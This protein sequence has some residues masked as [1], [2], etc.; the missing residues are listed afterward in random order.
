MGC[1]FRRSTKL[2]KKAT[3]AAPRCHSYRL[4]AISSGDAY[5]GR[6]QMSTSYEIYQTYLHG[7]TAVLRLFEQ[8]LGIQAIYGTPTPDMQQRTIECLSDEIGQLQSQ[9][10]RLQEELRDTRSDNHRLLRRNAELE[11]LV[12]KDSH[13]SSRPPSTDPLW[14][15]HTKSLRRPSGK[16]PGG[17]P[18]HRG[19]TLRLMQK[20]TRVLTHRPERCRHCSSPLREG[21]RTGTERRRVIDLVPIRLRVTEHRADIVRCPACGR[22]TKAEFTDGVRASVQYDPSVFA[23]ALYLHNYQLLP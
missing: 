11:A 15:K 12:S 22:R 10:S 2:S 23:R 6:A 9:I 4:Q 7:P 20:P 14:A 13:N 17:Q 21:H 5:C 1:L 18:G 3:C 19:H 16:R 8:A